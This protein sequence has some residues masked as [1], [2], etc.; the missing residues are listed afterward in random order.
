MDVFGWPVSSPN[1]TKTSWLD[2]GTNLRCTYSEMG[3]LL[4]TLLA[5]FH[6][7]PIKRVL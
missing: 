6:L 5:S 4:G 2:Q 7:I 1:K 3:L